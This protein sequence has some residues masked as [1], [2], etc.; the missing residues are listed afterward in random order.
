MRDYSLTIAANGSDRRAVL[1]NFIKVKTAS[2]ELRVRAEDKDGQ[3]V[4]DLLMSQGAYVNLPA[5]FQTVR[6]E[7]PTGS[8]TTATLIIGRGVVDDSQLSGE[9][10]IGQGQTLAAANHSL[11]TTAS[12]I[13][14]ASTTRRSLIIQN[15]DASIDVYIGPSGVTSSTGLKLAAGQ[16]VT[17][18]KAAA[19]AVYAV[20]ASGAP[21]IR[22]LTE[23][24]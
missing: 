13:L 15:I 24:D 2:V 23:S 21:A 4:A 22:T 8:S 18:D 5:E 12:E 14:A 3:S 1:G 11:T 6:I 7:N 19:A 20:A 10:T 16:S 9:V 17:I